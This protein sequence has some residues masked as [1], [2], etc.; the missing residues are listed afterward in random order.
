MTLDLTTYPLDMTPTVWATEKKSDKLDFIKIKNL[1]TS[2]DIINKV[3]RQPKEWEK[4][5]TKHISDKGF[6]SRLYKD[7]LQL[8]NEKTTQVKSG[9]KNWTDIFQ[10][11]YINGQ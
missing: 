6:I 1:Y 4:I 9:Q 10:R 8:N 11:Q 5:P 7:L 2:K 3:K